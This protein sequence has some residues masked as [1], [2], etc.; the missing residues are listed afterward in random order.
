MNYRPLSL[1]S[2]L[3]FTTL[4]SEPI[5]TI[6]AE[7]DFGDTAQL[8]DGFGFNY[9]E[10]CQTR[11][12]KDFMQDYGGFSL[13]KESSKQEISE[14]VFGDNGLQ[15]EIVKMFL[16]PWHQ[17]DP[18]GD[19]D[20]TTTTANMVRFVK[21][22]V[23]TAAKGE[24]RLEIITTLY[25]P[26]PW[27]T[28]QKQIGGRD[29]DSTKF[30]DLAEYMVDWARFLRSENIPVKYLSIHNEGEDFYRWDHDQGTQRFERFDY[31]AYWPPRQVNAFIKALARAVDQ[32]GIE[33]LGIT[34]GEPSNWTRFY[35][36][37]YARP[38]INDKEVLA[39]LDLLTT[40]GFVNGDYDKLSYGA[41]HG[42]T[43]ELLR[44]ERPDLH[45]WI[46]SYAWGGQSTKFVKM[47]FEHIYHAGVNALIPW[48]GIQYP[49]HWIEHDPNVGA[50]IKV[51]DDG[52]YE[53]LTGYYI[54]KQM[55]TAGHRG[56]AVA[57]TMAANPKANIIAFASNGTSHPDAFILAS[58]ITIWGLPFGIE[59]MNTPYK[60]FRAWRTT[61]DGSELC[62]DIGV[63]HV[64]D[65]R[66]TYEAPYGSITTFIGEN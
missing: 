29:L 10:T 18:D 58:D 63:F 59:V 40:H 50:A 36:W 22:G 27:A 30:A 61:Q 32:S 24:R 53:I 8:W 49:P 17:Q 11:D 12:Y 52:S 43:T 37:G 4:Q 66:I 57:H 38:L 7:V 48:A 51:V 3:I 16:D 19:F 46:T 9:V 62:K 35:N 60:K 15:V 42:T 47:S 56:M 2:C 20:H 21:D 13:M 44:S 28:L 41:V 45:A 64:Q 5:R 39:R 14:L 1:L 23:K 65:G 33:D 31:N 25:G 6:P 54:Y 34:N 26:P 55:T